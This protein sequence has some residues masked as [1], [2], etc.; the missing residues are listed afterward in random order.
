MKILPPPGPARTKQLVLLGLLVV[1]AAYT[2]SRYFS[3]EPPAGAPFSTSNSPARPMTPGEAGK[4]AMPQK[5]ALEKL[6]PVPEEPSAARNPFR[7]GTKAAPSPP[8]APAFVPPPV[9]APPM[10]GP[11]PPPTVLPIPLKF[12][13]RIVMPDTSVV[14]SLSDGRGNIISGVE[15][16]VIDGRYRIVR[17]GEE[18]IV[19]EYVNGTGRTTLPLR[20]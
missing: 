6:E 4:S 1:A 11:P 7:F 14:A 20:G 10:P 17:I 5:V 19:I 15:G 13:G 3:S 2:L 8:P 16:Q 9:V 18:S 12:I